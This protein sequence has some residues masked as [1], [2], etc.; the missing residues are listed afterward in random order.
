M[1]KFRSRICLLITC[2][3]M[4]GCAS[5]KESLVTGVGVGAGAGALV[6]SQSNREDRSKGAATGALIGAL[7]GGVSSYI[8]HGSLQKRDAKT[9][10]STLLKLDKYSVSS[11][12]NKSGVND[13]RLSAPDV[14]KEC[15]DWEVKN[16]KL[17][18]QHCVWTIRG[19]SYW[20]PEKQ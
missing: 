15:F 1:R 20:I 19:N 5:M 8:I 7:V 3:V 9:R 12:V 16:N 14:D 2:A 6:G 17:V 4:M 18:Q 10:K 13:F 11:P